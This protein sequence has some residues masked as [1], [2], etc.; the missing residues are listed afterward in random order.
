MNR[1]Y[2]RSFS[3]AKRLS[4]ELEV[5][6]VVTGTIVPREKFGK[7]CPAFPVWSAVLVD[8]NY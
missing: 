4:E 8:F 3:A 5:V 6:T 7:H 2:L 1:I